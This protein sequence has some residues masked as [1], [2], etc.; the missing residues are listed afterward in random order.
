LVQQKEKN[1]LLTK[2]R[3]EEFTCF[4][5]YTYQLMMTNI[6][7]FNKYGSNFCQKNKT[8]FFWSKKQTNLTNDSF[9]YSKINFKTFKKI[10]RR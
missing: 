2:K 8:D 4:T 7:I 10:K 5:F 6:M 1:L 3:R 9:Y